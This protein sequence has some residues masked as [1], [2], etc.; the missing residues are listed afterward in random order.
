MYRYTKHSP[1]QRNTAQHSATQRSARAETLGKGFRD[2]VA[3]MQGHAASRSHRARSHF[4]F[5][6]GIMDK[7]EYHERELLGEYQSSEKPPRLSEAVLDG[8]SSAP[9][10]QPGREDA[11]HVRPNAGDPGAFVLLWSN[12][13]GHGEHLVGPIIGAHLALCYQ[14]SGMCSPSAGDPAQASVVCIKSD[15]FDLPTGANTLQ[16]DYTAIV[17]W[18]EITSTRGALRGRLGLL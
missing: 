3:D 2:S 13:I 12:H 4:Q 11:C 5:S 15:A 6:P 18:P 10:Y 1:S 7:A 17:G 14:P 8:S 16:R 9:S